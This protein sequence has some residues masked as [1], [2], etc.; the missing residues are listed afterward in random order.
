MKM[1]AGEEAKFVKSQTQKK[2]LSIK[3]QKPT[4]QS[5]TQL[6]SNT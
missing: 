6:R 3:Q 2:M 5:K 1:N 4:L